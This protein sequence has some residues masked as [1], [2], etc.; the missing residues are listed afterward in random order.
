MAPAGGS[1]Q[2]FK[3]TERASL[4]V[5]A[6]VAAHDGLDSLGGFIGVVEGDGADIVVKNVGFDDAV[7]KLAAYETEL[8]IDGCGGATNIVP[9]S[10]G[11]VGERRV[12]VL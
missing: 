6:V 8:S 7:Q 2:A 9:A 4:D 11:V 1:P 12:G 5:G 10:S 3:E